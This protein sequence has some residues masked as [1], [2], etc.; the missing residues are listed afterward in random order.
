VKGVTFENKAR[1]MV[2]FVGRKPT[3]AAAMAAL[4]QA[5]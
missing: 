5:A 2:A 4:G 3:P 1:H